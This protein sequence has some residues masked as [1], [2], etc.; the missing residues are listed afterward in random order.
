MSFFPET[1]PGSRRGTGVCPGEKKTFA[2]VRKC[3]IMFTTRTQ[4]NIARQ[5]KAAQICRPKSH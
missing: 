1:S 5:A 4:T 3:A 2:N